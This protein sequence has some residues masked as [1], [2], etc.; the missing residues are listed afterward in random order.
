MLCPFNLMECYLSPR[1][2]SLNC[3]FLPIKLLLMGQGIFTQLATLQAEGLIVTLAFWT[4]IFPP[5]Q[6]ECPLCSVVSVLKAR[7]T[8][9]QTPDHSTYDVGA[10]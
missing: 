1:H 5:I 2:E 7:K 10:K 8:G 6:K 4:G 9:L 3:T